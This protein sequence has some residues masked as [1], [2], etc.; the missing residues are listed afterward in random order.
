MNSYFV[1]ERQIEAK[2]DNER[3]REREREREKRSRSSTREMEMIKRGIMDK[4]QLSNSGERD[5]RGREITAPS[6]TLT[7]NLIKDNSCQATG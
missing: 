4:G 3:E 7:Y 1:R 6:S 2:R 5:R